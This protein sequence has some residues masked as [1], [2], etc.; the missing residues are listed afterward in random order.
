M[1]AERTSRLKTLVESLPLN[2]EQIKTLTPVS[3]SYIIPHNQKRSRRYGLVL[4]NSVDRSGAAAE[5]D[6][7]QQ[8]LEEA[9]CDVTKMEWTNAVELGS[10]INSALIRMMSDCSL[11]IVCLMS[12]GCQ[13]ALSA[14]DGKEIPVNDILHQL[15]YTLPSYV[16]L[17]RMF[18]SFCV[19]TP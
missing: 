13:G 6:N 7:I 15:S 4:F 9:G 16:P 8:A 17:V 19:L 12:H 14:S 11:L 10:M 1:F 3:S 5:A 2:V 18:V